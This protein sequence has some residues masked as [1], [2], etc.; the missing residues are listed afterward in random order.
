M[1]SLTG[2]V[3]ATLRVLLRRFE[4]EF[5]FCTH[6]LTIDLE[7]GER[8]IVALEPKSD[9]TFDAEVMA[10]LADLGVPVEIRTTP[11]ELAEAI[12]FEEGDT[13]ASYDPRTAQLCWRQLLQAARVM[14]R[15]RS[16]FIGKVSPVHFFWGAL[17]LACTRFS[18]G[19]PFATPAAPNVGDWVMVEGYSHELSS[20][21]FWPG[22]DGEGMFYAYAYP[23]RKASPS[24]P[25]VRGR[26][27]LRRRWA[28]RASVPDRPRSRRPR[29]RTYGVPAEDVRSGGDPRPLGP[30]RA[31][32]RP[33]APGDA[34]LTWRRQRPMTE[35]AP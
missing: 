16:H 17:D 29:L 30:V 23:G 10:A 34:A 2:A 20:C 24:T 19:R 9:A 25:S 13:H 33:A 35:S 28:V 12:R 11:V 1:S 22:G 8:R 15:F 27:L 21:G 7:G 26:L 5:Y 14:N 32:G 4:I 6:E 18:G 3:S 31:R